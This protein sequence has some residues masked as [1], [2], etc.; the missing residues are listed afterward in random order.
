M[1]TIYLVTLLLAPQL[2]L[3]PFVGIP[4][5]AILFPIWFLMVFLKSRLTPDKI[6][7]QD[8]CFVLLI[9]WMIVSMVMNGSLMVE[10]RDMG[11]V[12]SYYAKI[13]VLYWFLSCSVRSSGQVKTVMVV[14]VILALLLSI[15]GIQHKLTGVGWAGQKLGWIDPEV[16][17]AGGTGR[18]RWVGIFDGPGVFAVIYTVALP[19]VLAGL[20]KAFPLYVRIVSLISLPLIAVATYFNGSRGG[21]LATLA[22][23]VLYFGKNLKRSKVSAFFGIALAVGFFVAA[24]AYMTEVND[25]SKSS[26]HRIEMWSEGF[27]MVTTHPIFGIGRGNFRSY[28]GSLVAHNSAVEIMGETGFIGLLIWISL[29]YL[30]MK[31]AY[32]YAKLAEGQTDRLI[33]WALFVAI[34]GYVVSSMFVTLEYE[35]FYFLLAIAGVL[36][37]RLENPL[38]FGKRDLKIVVL[39]G[40]GWLAFTYG[41]INWYKLRYF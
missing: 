3:Q 38:R 17:V 13:A 20:N 12:I 11:L 32:L 21:F 33:A 5:H 4:V 24:P 18:T 6:L 14:F 37:R 28:T 25:G 1:T 41:L 40:L 9:L 10:N 36:G 16:L 2:W 7:H 15:E 8:L 22:V 23:F 30:S 35:T 19:F 26:Y 31:N 39:M 29:V 27:E 34:A